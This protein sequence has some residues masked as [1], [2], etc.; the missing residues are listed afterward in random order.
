[1]GIVTFDPAAWKAR[2]PEFAQVPDLTATAYF[3]E[4]TIYCRNDCSP[5]DP[6]TLA[7]FLNM[8]T[9]HIA[10]LNY[11][12]NGSP[13]S[14]I[15]GRISDATEGSVHVATQNDYAP[16][17]VQWYQQ[18]KYGSAYWAASAAF[19]TMRY[20][21]NPTRVGLSGVYPL[22]APRSGFVP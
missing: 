14:P 3:N 4:A 20:V 7:V 9:A 13:S 5:V 1:M 19:R 17:T 11:A 21:A 22:V 8:L 18:T 12:F 16:G 6:T 2:Y 15:V 10:A